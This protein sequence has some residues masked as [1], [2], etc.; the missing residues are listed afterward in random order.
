MDTP[1]R[2]LVIGAHPD[3]ADFGAGG[4]IAL[5]ASQGCEVTVACVTD[6]DSGG[7]DDAVPRS[8]V[9]EI[10]REEQRAA[11]AELGAKDVRFLGRPDGFVTVD[12]DLRRDLARLVREVRPQAVVTH[13]PERNYRFVF[14]YHPDHLATGA[15][16]LAAVYPDARNAFAFPDLDLEPWEVPQV[17]LFGGPQDDTA[18]DVTDVFEAKVRA[19]SAHDSQTPMLDRSVEAELRDHLGRT[20][21]EHGLPEGRLAEAYQVLN[22][23]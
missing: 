23:A 19:C 15:A 11:A 1:T 18:V 16:V 21:A 3:D 7:F 17:W 8:E 9:P 13:S 12:R 20:A 4:L 10:R 5:W 2:A 22:T 6:G 14:L